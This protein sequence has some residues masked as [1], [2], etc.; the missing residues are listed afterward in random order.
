MSD[1]HV[2]NHHITDLITYVSSFDY[3]QQTNSAVIRGFKFYSVCIGLSLIT[4]CCATKPPVMCLIHVHSED[5][6]L[7]H[8][9][10]VL[11]LILFQLLSH[12]VG[13]L[14]IDIKTLNQVTCFITYN[15]PK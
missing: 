10:A 7:L 12:N 6:G 4:Q 13:L 2:A 9:F 5:T 11:L 8:V 1:L 14:N 15:T 3:L